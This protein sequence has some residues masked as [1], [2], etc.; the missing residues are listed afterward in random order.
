MKN[1]PDRRRGQQPTQYIRRWSEIEVAKRKVHQEAVTSRRRAAA[2]AAADARLA[3]MKRCRAATETKRKAK[4]LAKSE[5]AL[6]AVYDKLDLQ[7]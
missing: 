4:R 5:A 2:D 3:D 1:Q 6:A 7:H